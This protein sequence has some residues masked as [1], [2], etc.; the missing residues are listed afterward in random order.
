MAFVVGNAIG[1]DMGSASS[2]Y[3]QFYRGTK[4]TLS[5][6]LTAIQ[7]TAA[8]ILEGLLPEHGGIGRPRDLRQAREPSLIG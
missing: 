6:S 4:E 8:R 2:D 7:Q 3:I 5:E 1:L